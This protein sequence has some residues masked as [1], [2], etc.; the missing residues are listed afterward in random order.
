MG[1][2]KV[3]LIDLTSNVSNLDK[4]LTRFID[5]KNFHPILASEIVERVHGLTSFVAENPCQTMLQEI[6]DIET[7]YDLKLP[8]IEYRDENYNLNE[9]YDYIT[10]IKRSLEEEVTQIKELEVFIEKYE[11]ALIQVKNIASLDVS[12]DDLFASQ[13]ISIRFG[14]LPIDSVEKLRFFQNRP[15]AFKSF[16]T[17]H[18]Y[19]WC[20]YFTTDEYKREVDNIFSSLFFERSF[21]PDFVHGTP[22]EAAERIEYEIAHARN[23]IMKYRSDMCNITDG[24]ENRLSMIKGELLFLNRLFESKKYVV[25]LGDKFTISG[26]AE[27]ADVK[28]FQDTFKDMTD[29]EIEVNAADTDKRV[30]PP[31]KL[32]NGWFSKPFGMF[33]EMYGLPGYNELDP[34]PFVAITYSILFGIMFGDLGQGL[35]L[36][37]L[38]YLA[39]KFKGMRLGAVGVRIGLSSAIFGLLYGSFFGN[40]E[41][42][43]PFFTDIL[44]LPG[45]PIHIMDSD[46]TMTLLISAIAIGALLILS[47]MILNIITMIKKK[48]YVEMVFSHNGIAGMMMYGFVVVAAGLQVGLGIPVVNIFTILGFV[49]IPLIMIFFK[50]PVHRKIHKHP[51]FPAG[52]GGFFIEAFFELFEIVLSYL[53]NSMSFL[54]VGGFVLSHAGMMLVVF[55]L[56]GMVGNASLLV[57]ILGNIFVMVLEGMIVGIQVLRLQFYEMFSRYYSGNGIAFNPIN[58]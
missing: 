7:K 17:D 58:Q 31:T 50:E 23:Q 18:N 35:V 43:T 45:K 41:I 28:V 22:K 49:A 36:M 13:Y 14:R 52:F 57:M 51:M 6:E 10:E 37:L 44:G 2:A 4:V 54:R 15:F 29:V 39:Y 48:D 53:T 25:G 3:N 5:L 38:G 40:E 33:V 1:I 55:T 47:T 32:K 16:N 34:T 20:M 27:D 24:C 9:M 12:L 21:I 11:N 8:N 56:M 26:F 19:V 30:T 42:L 46:F